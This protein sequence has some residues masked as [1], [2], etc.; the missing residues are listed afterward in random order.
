MNVFLGEDSVWDQYSGYGDAA[1][2]V[3]LPTR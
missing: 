2:V 3:V 1:P